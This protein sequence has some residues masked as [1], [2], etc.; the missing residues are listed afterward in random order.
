MTRVVEAA[1]D[2][3]RPGDTVLLAPGC[4]SMDLFTDY[5]A[6]G[7][8]VRRGG[9]RTATGCQRHRTRRSARVTTANP[10]DARQRRRRGRRRPGH[11]SPGVAPARGWVRRLAAR[12]ARP[13]ADVLLPAAR[14][15]RAAAHHRPDHGA[16]RLERLSFAPRRRLL[17]DRAAPAALGR[18]SALPCACVA[19]RGCRTVGCAGSPTRPSSSSLVLLRSP[20]GLGV[21]VNGNKN[22]LALGPVAIQPVRDRQARAR[23][24]GRP[25]LRPQGAPPR[26]A[27]PHRGPGGAGHVAG[28]SRLVVAR[29]RPRHRAGALRDPA[30]DA[31]GRR[32]PGPALRR[33]DRRSLGVVARRARGHRRRAA[34]AASPTSSTRSRT[35][36]APAG[37]RP[38]ASTRCRPA[39]ASARASAPASRS[40]APCPRPTPT[41]SSPCSARSSAWS[42]RCSSSRCSSPSPSPAIRVARA[43]TTRSC[44]TRPSG[45]VVWLI[46][47][48]M[49]NVGMVLALL[50]GHRHPAAAGLLRRLRLLPSLV[51][52]GLLVGSPAASPRRPRAGRSA[53]GSRS[54]RLSAGRQHASLGWP[55]CASSSPAAA[56]PATP[57][58]CSPPPTRC[59]GSTPTSRSPAS[60]PRAASRPGSCPRPATRSS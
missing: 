50:P 54:R 60:A 57:R 26:R 38:T 46:G 19:S 8:R 23:P 14:R 31:V 59:A 37:S 40:G 6:R 34:R 11:A 3:A 27:A 15:L 21:E 7:R 33:L 9:A 29:P 51:A 22:W 48:M 2:L 49:I 45:I 56:P 39:A 47:Q 41:S 4:A 13:A 5:A 18:C 24:L 16:E 30:R 32:R 10:E 28:R 42:A 36:T 17:H 53:A 25:H 55:R 52:L 35:T 20:R 1:A 12:G 43:P 44:A 58:P